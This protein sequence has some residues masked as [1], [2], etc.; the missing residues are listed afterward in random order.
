MAKTGLMFVLTGLFL[1]LFG[2][3]LEKKRRQLMQ[4]IKSPTTGVIS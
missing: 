1:I 4:Q 2:V 3:F